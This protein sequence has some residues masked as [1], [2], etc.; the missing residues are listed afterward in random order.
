MRQPSRDARPTPCVVGLSWLDVTPAPAS[1]PGEAYG[2]RAPPSAAPFLP[3]RGSLAGVAHA[4]ALDHAAM[5]SAIAGRS[6]RWCSGLALV[7]RSGRACRS[8]PP[9]WGRGRG[10]LPLGLAPPAQHCWGAPCSAS[11]NAGRGQH[12][13]DAPSRSGVGTLLHPA[14][15]ATAAGEPAHEPCLSRPLSPPPR[16]H[17]AAPA[18]ATL[19]LGTHRH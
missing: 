7:Q 11:H 1:S 13:I 19:A 2:W 5:L 16:L 8:C 10:V 4:P 15:A 9:I 18:A 14:P 3:C 12:A 6:R 17:P